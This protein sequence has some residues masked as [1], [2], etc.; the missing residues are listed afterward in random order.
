M[1]TASLRQNESIVQI[2]SGITQ[3][4]SVVQANPATSEETAASAEERSAQAALLDNIVSR[5]KLK[6]KME[7]LVTKE[8]VTLLIFDLNNLK[9][10]NDTL[11]ITE[12][13]PRHPAKRH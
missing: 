8:S 5:F 10:I 1:R 4:S 11:V 7:T 2:T 13:S 3:L 6:D 9:V 12:Y